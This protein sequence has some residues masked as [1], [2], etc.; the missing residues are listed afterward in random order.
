MPNQCTNE[1]N[2]E[3]RWDNLPP[4]QGG[5]SRHKCAACAYYAGYSEGL[6]RSETLD[7]DFEVLPENQ[8]GTAR[9]KSPQAAYAL[10]YYEGVV[11]S[12]N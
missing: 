5:A 7:I 3:P 12:H 1:H 8:G 10:G 2:N 4:Y 11:A 6:S 9:H